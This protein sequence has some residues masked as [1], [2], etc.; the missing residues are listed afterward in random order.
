[1][2]NNKIVALICSIL[3]N[4]TAYAFLI[5]K[6]KKLP[7]CL[8]RYIIA[9]NLLPNYKRIY[10]NILTFTTLN[11][12]KEYLQMATFVNYKTV[13]TYEK[14]VDRE[15]YYFNINYPETVFLKKFLANFLT[16]KPLKKNRNR[17]GQMENFDL[18]HIPL[19]LQKQFNKI[20]KKPGSTNK[21]NIFLEAHDKIHRTKKK[22]EKY[23]LEVAAID[24]N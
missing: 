18:P 12:K 9:D 16:V 7:P 17:Y 5:L 21:I 6:L 10:R 2:D 8:I 3:S 1:M 22:L 13:Y 19:F 23:R 11:Q 15:S 14:I 24:M 4:H 20:C